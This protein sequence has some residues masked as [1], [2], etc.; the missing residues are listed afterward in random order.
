[1]PENKR[2]EYHAISSSLQGNPRHI[3]PATPKY[4]PLYLFISLSSNATNISHA[5]N[6][7]ISPNHPPPS[8]CISVN[9]ASLS[10]YE[11]LGRPRWPPRRSLLRFLSRAHRCFPFPTRLCSD[12]IPPERLEICVCAGDLFV[13]VHHWLVPWRY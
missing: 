12:I 11:S 2:C 1:M 10:K 5:I 8:T 6:L 13:L 3:P 9:T 7:R 4:V